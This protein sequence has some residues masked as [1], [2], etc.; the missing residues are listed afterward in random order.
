MAWENKMKRMEIITIRVSNNLE[1]QARQC[2]RE[3][4]DTIK[5]QT[6]LDTDVY[7]N[8]ST[9][10]DLAIIISSQ[11]GQCNSQGTDLGVH[12][13]GMMKRFGLVDHTCWFMMDS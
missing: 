4:C 6:L 11:A 2:M 3:F 9:P 5:Q 12:V 13:A 1:R 8:A 10:G 7:V